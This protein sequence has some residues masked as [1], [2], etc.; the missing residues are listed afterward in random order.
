M[1]KDPKVI[2]RRLRSSYFISIISISLLLFMVGLMGFLVLNA[3]NLSEYVKE[4]ISF[5]VILDEEIKEVDIIRIQ[6]NLDAARYVKSTRYIT[7]ERAASELEDMLGEDFISFLGYNPLSPSIE[8]NLFAAWANPD[9]IAVIEKDIEQFQDV[10]EVY[11]QKS[12]VHLVNENIRRISIIITA[13]SLMLFLI[14][15]SL[16]NNT[17]RLSVYARRFI[18]NTMKLV[19]A[20]NAFIRRPFLA[21]S[22]AHGLYAA[23][24]AN[25]LMFGLIYTVQKEFADLFGFHDLQTI[26]L[27]FLSIVILGIIINWI[28]TF[29]AVSRYLRMKTDDLY[30]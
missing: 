17:I 20:T 11:Y 28:S 1:K 3:R 13:F 18:I 2:K 30:Y 16:I 14:S 24:L 15:L 8:V 10:Q 7:K 22:A 26:G 21:R 5:S 27:L 9:S 29:F 19:G 12:L 25:G 6:K 4:N 23:I